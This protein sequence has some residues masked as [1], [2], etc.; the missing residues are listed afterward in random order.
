MEIIEAIRSKRA[1]RSFTDQ[2]VPDEVIHQILDA[3]RRAQSSRNS[4]PWTFIVV[5]DRDRLHRLSACGAYAQPLSG[6]CFGV[7]LVS[8][9]EWAFDL[10]QAAAY[11]Q[12]AGWNFEVSSCPVWLGDSD[13]VRDLLGIPQD[14][15]VEM[16]IAFGYAK[17]AQTGSAKKG[18]RKPFNEVVRWEKWETE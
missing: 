16:A 4:Q 13:Q 3:G 15:Y 11:L 14:Q 2:V 8:S 10:G 1:V 18:G 6:A 12:L 9:V 5:R 7:V 17:T